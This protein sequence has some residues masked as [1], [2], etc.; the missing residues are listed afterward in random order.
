MLGGAQAAL[1]GAAR[2]GL[3]YTPFRFVT[4]DSPPVDHTGVANRP[5][6]SPADPR[7]A[8][9][10]DPMS[11]LEIFRIGGDNGS[12]L[13]IDS[14]KDSGLKFPCRLRQDN[15]PRMQK[16]WN[17]DSTL[18]VIER[19]FPAKGDAGDAGSYLIDVHGSHGASRPWCIIRAS[20]KNGL[21]DKVGNIWFWDFLNPLRA[22]VPEADGMYEWW[23]VGGPGHSTGEKNF[24]FAW[25]GGFSKFDRPRRGRLQTSH[26]GLT[27]IAE[28]RRNSDGRWGG[29]RTNLHTGAFGPFVPHPEAD[30]GNDN[31]WGLN[32]TSANG[33]YAQFRS[34]ANVNTRF[35]FDCITGAAVTTA[36]NEFS[37]ADYAEVD[38]VQYNVG[39]RGGN[40]NMY[41]IVTGQSISKGDFPGNN[42]Q[43]TATRNFKDTFENHGATGGSTSGL[44]YAL[45]ARSTSNSGH[46]RG[47]MGI[48][49]G[50]RDFN[51]VRYLANHRS[52]RS[53]GANECH[54]NVSP[55][56]EYV[57]FNSNWHEPGIENDGDVHPYVV[58]VPS[59]WRSPNNDGS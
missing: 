58:I 10:I 59:A 42:P 1:L 30:S 33:Q 28:C 56:F 24:L 13:F 29:F 51:T 15:N 9:L 27:Y 6:Y 22:Y 4:T 11:G 38:G 44:R 45:W 26:D 46:P 57:V 53:T 23:P 36:K 8:A 16:V 31:T 2:A 48:R 7:S 49:L 37:H 50:A 18:L 21:G 54:P 12:P 25:P 55:D 3:A 47:I 17:A 41:D 19:R 35:Y 34:V 40:Y 14:T 20:S 43:H 5:G 39:Y 52:V 32:G